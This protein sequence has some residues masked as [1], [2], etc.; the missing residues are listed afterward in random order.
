M[1]I[2]IDIRLLGRGGLTGVEEY[3]RQI[4]THLL[5]SDSQNH[6]QLF[7]N[8][9][10]HKPLSELWLKKNTVS[11]IDWKI[12]NRLLDMSMRFWNGPKIDKLTGADLV[13]SPHFNILATADKPRLITI[14]DL[15]FLHH[16]YFFSM[17]ERLWQWSQNF[18]A[19]V[20]TASRVITDSEFTQS[21]INRRLGIPKERILVIYPG[22]DPALKKLDLEDP[23]LANFKKLRGL[24]FPF[25]LYLGT[26]EPRKN[27]PAIIKAFSL[28]KTQKRFYDLELV[29][30]GRPGWL[31]KDILKTAASSPVKN[32]IIFWGPV[33][34]E[35]KIFLY[36]LAEV[37]VYPSFFEGFGFPPLEA[38]KCG[39][40]AVVADRTSLPEIMNESALMI[41]PWRVDDLTEVLE[42]L[43]T[44]SKLRGEL[45]RKGLKNAER[46][47]WQTTAKEILKLFHHV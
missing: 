33:K 9:W 45:V 7:Y 15:S 47:N 26:L 39:C 46:F 21:D 30:A 18:A 5:N 44:Q 25:L 36:N 4:V 34:N 43:L 6:Y 17:R 12:P 13:F 23:E 14:H 10:R 40:P 24:N 37:F 20:R 38:Q 22:V 16:P 2:L 28:L 1:N 29:I 11:V 35:D 8:S 19:Q 41:N 31:Y 42:T 32:D 27:I 3:T